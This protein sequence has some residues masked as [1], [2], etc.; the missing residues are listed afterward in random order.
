MLSIYKRELRAYFTSPIGYIFVAVF[1]A[2]SAALFC[3]TTLFSL[4]ADLTSYFSYMIFVFIILL[5]LL[6]MRLFSEERKQRTE[7]LLLTAP[8]SIFSMVA[9][10]FFA[11]YTVFGGSM[12]VSSVPFLLLYHY[13][14]VKTA[15]VLGNLV[16]VLL[17][18]MAFIAIGV[19]IS[20][21]TENQLAAAVGTIGILL[22]FMVIGMLNSII[23]VYFIRMIL[24]CVSVFSRFQNFTQGVLDVSALVYYLSVTVVFLFLTMRV[25]DK[26]RYS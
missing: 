9:A 5:P 12:L 22:A 19:F 3:Y 13:A 1:L 6:T 8:V 17:V 15:I 25:Y 10:K 11:A 20:A 7:Q 2:I 23:P 14:D 16:A 26:R 24:S 4:S 21:L 18:G